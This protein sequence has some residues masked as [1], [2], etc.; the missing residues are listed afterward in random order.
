[1]ASIFHKIKVLPRGLSSVL[2]NRLMDI[3]FQC[4]H[5]MLLHICV[6]KWLML[7]LWH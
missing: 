4:L 5:Y 6:V 3:Y 7:T 2:I 1:M